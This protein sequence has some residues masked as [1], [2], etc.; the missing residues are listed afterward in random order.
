MIKDKELFSRE[1]PAEIS[2][3]PVIQ[4]DIPLNIE[5][6]DLPEVVPVLALRGA[7]IFPHAI[8]PLTVGRPKSIKLIK[9]AETHGLLI[10]TVP[11]LDVNFEEPGE[12]D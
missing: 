2:V 4:G 7:V 9:E 8:F 11:Q 1:T 6:K 10:G 5:E 3:I 12:E